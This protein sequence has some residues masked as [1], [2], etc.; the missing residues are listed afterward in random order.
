M[1]ASPLLSS[2]IS[3]DTLANLLGIRPET[4]AKWRRQG[5]GPEFFR[6][7]EKRVVYSHIAIELWL[8]SRRSGVIGRDFQK[9]AIS[10]SPTTEEQSAP[11]SRVPR[12]RRFGGVRTR[13]DRRRETSIH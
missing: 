4:L 11:S 6:L 2:L 7:N 10:N 13:E 8:Q 9:R 3:A 1:P 5:R 12:R